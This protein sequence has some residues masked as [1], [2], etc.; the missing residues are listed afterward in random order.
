MSKTHEIHYGIGVRGR[1]RAVVHTGHEFDAEGNII[2]EGKVLRESAWGKNKITLPGFDAMLSNNGNVGIRMAAG[3]GNASPAE[4]NTTLQSYA[5][6]TN[7]FVSQTKTKNNVPDGDGN[8]TVTCL[9]RFTF[10]PNSL[11]SSPINVTEAGA[12]SN[13]GTPGP[14]T[15]VYSRGLLVDGAGNPTAVPYDAG[16]EYLDLYWEVTYYI[17][18][19]VNGTVSITVDGVPT[20]FAYKVRPMLFTTYWLVGGS[21]QNLPGIY[22]NTTS[23]NGNPQFSTNCSGNDLGSLDGQP[24]GSYTTTTRPSVTLAS[25]TAGSKQ[26]GITLSWTPSAGNIAGGIRSV[27]LSGCDLGGGSQCQLFQIQ[28]DPKLPKDSDHSMS[29]TFVL[30]MGNK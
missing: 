14:S 7:A 17:P 22:Y 4:S 10:N 27:L 6:F 8:V 1:Y 26:R 9:Y 16:V 18:A 30:T 3:T 20:D 25:Y 23:S 19:E 21:N 12:I 15:T 24:S 29:L 11:G 13:S 5:G 2:K 28:Y